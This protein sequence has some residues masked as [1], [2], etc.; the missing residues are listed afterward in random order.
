MN[1]KQLL[2]GLVFMGLGL[3]GCG[4][5]RYEI[6]PQINKG[7]HGGNMVLIDERVSRYIEF[8]ATPQGEEWLLQL[9]AYNRKMKPRDFS[10]YARVEVAINTN[11]KKSVNLYNTKQWFL[12]WSQVG[13]LEGKISM[14]NLKKFKADV[15]LFQGK[16]NLKPDNLYFQYP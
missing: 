4:F 1:S 3:S 14:G 15:L 10:S 12:P 6:I 8:V 16:Q 9:Y 5:F 7:P 2:F 11:E 13:H